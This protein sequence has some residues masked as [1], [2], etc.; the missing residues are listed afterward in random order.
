MKTC[1]S[2]Y[3]FGPYIKS[4]D[5]GI[6]GAID[7]ASENG[8]DGI[9]IVDGM[10]ENCSDLEL[11]KKVNEYCKE[12]GIEV[13]SFCTGADFLFGSGGD[14]DAEVERVCRIVD[15]AHAYGAKCFRHD[16]AYG[17]GD[18]REYKFYENAIPRL[19]EGCRR[20][21]EY[22]EKLGIITTTENHGYYSQDCQRVAALISAV[23]YDNF[24]ALVDIGNFMCADET[25]YK[26]VAIVAPYAK[27]VHAKDF[28]FKSCLDVNPG[29]GWFRSRGNNYLRGAIIGHGDA[30]A[31]QSLSILKKT[32]YDGYISIEFEGHEDRLI[33]IKMGHANV[34]RFW[35]MA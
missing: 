15:L 6:F 35:E 25:P 14:L 13:A 26:S 28:Y 22:A 29:E 20:V 32:G 16:V 2:T 10:H 33:G 31:F 30:G 19:A 3:S 12:K 7:F 17:H 34:K 8:F 4:A 27:M 9:E 11:A 1:V 23:D 24:G 18:K 5:F 21:S